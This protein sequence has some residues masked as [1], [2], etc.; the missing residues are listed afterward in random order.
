MPRIFCGPLSGD[1]QEKCFLNSMLSLQYPSGLISLLPIG[2]G[3][4]EP[5]AVFS[6]EMG[7]YNKPLQEG[8]LVPRATYLMKKPEGRSQN[9]N[10]ESKLKF[11]KYLK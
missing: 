9:L 3:S 5:L 7:G 8:T 1:Q 6:Q 11:L 4:I 2:D 10:P